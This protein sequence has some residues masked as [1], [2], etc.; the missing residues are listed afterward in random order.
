MLGIIVDE[1]EVEQSNQNT[2]QN[3]ST[4]NQ[5]AIDQLQGEPYSFDEA[6]DKRVIDEEIKRH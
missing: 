5:Q 3:G 4:T 6:P 2:I 1:F